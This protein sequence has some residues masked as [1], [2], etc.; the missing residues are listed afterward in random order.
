[1]TENPRQQPIGSVSGTAADEAALIATFYGG[2]DQAPIQMVH[3]R[4]YQSLAAAPNSGPADDKWE[5]PADGTFGRRFDPP[6]RAAHDTTVVQVALNAPAAAAEAWRGMRHRLENVLEAKDLD[7]VWG[8]TLVY[9]AV[10]KQGIEADAA[11]NGMLPVFQRLR[12]SGHVEPLA[13]ADVSG[14][15]VWLVDVHDR[16][17]G[18]DAGTVYV[19]LGPPDGEEAL[20]DVFYGPAAL[21]LAPDTIAH[22]GYYEMRQYLGGDLE[23]RYAE[24]IEYLNETTDDLLQDLERREVKSDKLDELFRTYNRLLPVVSGLKELRTGLLQQLA[25]Y[26]WWRTHIESNEVI[27]FHR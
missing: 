1:M 21:L 18:F 4:L 22:K 19:T 11:F 3:E 23:R 2:R 5:N 15:R 14:G 6:G 9:Q 7:G 12:S 17:D 26:D 25:N 10:L 13:Q 20:L 8:Y 16:G 24:S 27:D